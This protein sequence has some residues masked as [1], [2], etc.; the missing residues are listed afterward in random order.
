MPELREVVITSAKRTPVGAFQGTLASI[1]AHQLGATAIK[2]VLVETGVD[3]SSIDEVIMGNVLSAGQGQAPARQAALGAGLPDSVECIT[4]NKMCGSGL[5]SVMLATQAIQT[6]DADI[7]IAGGMENMTQAPYL[8]PKGREGH[9]LGHGE[10]IDS[11]IKDGLWDA[12]NDKHMGNCAEMCARD[13]DYSREDQDEFAKTSY[14]RA[15]SA[16]ENGLFSNEIAP[17]SVP[18]RKSDPV[19]VDTDEEPGRANF[20]KMVSLRPAFE[21]D[22]TITAAN[23]SKIND[24]GAAVMVMSAEKAKELGLIPL[25]RIVAQASAAH[26]P[27]W[28]TTA[29]MKAITKVLE[30]ADL[31]V[32]EIDLWEINEAF[33]PV[34]MA[35]I[36]EFNLDHSK[37]NVNGGAIALGH[38][39][40]GS[41][42][43][44]LTTLI[45]AM[46][47]RDA[48]TGLATLCIGGGEA[49]AVVITR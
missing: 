32:E 36:D 27:E 9:R 12:Y 1:S 49:S 5:K 26:E 40:G 20:D 39:I 6:G 43:R 2:A 17:V 28:F 47:N 24:G 3:P 25:A 14:S 13:K 22:G 29:P 31:T 33:A 30:K 15:K 11:M 16:Q 21:K 42:A 4:I 34:A 8:L 7:I 46:K 23:A 38:P 44:I 37:V 19:I 45:H 10:I 35:P 41:G 48:H 18:Q